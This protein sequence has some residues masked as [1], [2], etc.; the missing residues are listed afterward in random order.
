[1]LHARFGC[2]LLLTLFGSM[3]CSSRP[4]ESH[5][6]EQVQVAI[7]ASADAKGGSAY[8]WRSVAIGGGG[9][10]S[11]QSMDRSGTTHVV[12]ADVYGAYIWEDRRDRWEPLIT[13][14]S[15]PAD[16]LGQAPFKQGVYE[17]VVAPSNPHRIYLAVKDAVYRSDDRGQH[18]IRAWSRTQSLKFEPNGAYR[19][20]GPFMD[21]SPTDPDTVLLGTPADGLW[22][23]SDGG[24][25]WA[26]VDSVPL[27][28]D[29]DPKKKGI[30]TPGIGIIRDPVSGELIAS[31]A[32]NG[33]Y[34]STDGGQRFTPLGGPSSGPGPQQVQHGIFAADHAFIGT[35]P[36]A[37]TVWRFADGRW[38]DIGATVAA[39]PQRFSAIAMNPADG[40]IFVFDNG[41]TGY[42][43][44]DNGQSW[45][46]LTRGVSAG[47]KDP[48]WLGKIDHASYFGVSVALFDPKVPGRLWA[49][50][51]T[52]VYRA[53]LPPIEFWLSWV[54]QTRG[55]EELVANDVIAPP[56]GSPV[57]AAWDFGIH[58]KPD[59][60]QY[61][62]TW[63]PEPRS[64]ISAQQVDWSVANPRFIVT[65]ASD[66]RLGCCSDDGKSVLAGYSEDGGMTWTRFPTLPT[67]PGT[68]PG[69]PWA[70][71]FGTIAVS[72]GDTNNI[73]WE[74]SFNRS[75]YYTLD[76]G[77]TWSRVVLAGELLPFTGSHVA[78]HLARRTLVAD[79][80]VGGRFYL[81]HSGEW[82]N[83]ALKGVWRTDDGGRNWR[84]VFTGEV[85]PFS[86]F[87]AKLR[88]V[89]G[90]AG[91]LFFSSSVLGT[92]GDT[93]L[94]R[95]ENGG[96]TWTI[97][98][99]IN[100]VDDIAFGKAAPGADYPAI[101][102]SGQINGR[103]GLWRSLDNAA[104]WQMISVYPMGRVDQVN[105]VAADLERFGRVYVGFVGSGWVYGDIGNC[106]TVPFTMDLTSDCQLITAE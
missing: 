14:T 39:R 1:M 25:N 24:K 11:G 85:A 38:T 23:T 57:F 18:F 101:Y 104:H 42:R 66:I 102:L 105:V 73:V 8:L 97:L 48:P 103:Y 94:R 50:S 7:K 21:V 98:G 64:L 96:E 77:K 44:A 36:V 106:Q 61:S 43:S 45:R 22:R 89:P 74:P 79:R 4:A 27:P 65:N 37:R 68:K 41:G 62:V 75:P 70:M 63:G 72:S 10:L 78:P 93:R 46:R 29:I 54:S 31:S 58:T 3:A 60:D 32:G 34:K 16:E 82:G 84:H 9:Y 56:G 30:Q 17:V 15:M 49:T 20:F 95:S 12:R 13:S 40:T 59:L 55:I 83:N 19:F 69:D 91:H 86:T 87:A 5:S 26:R 81:L 100:E 35:D 80:A 47:D 51:G 99:N 2:V 76:R 92:G 67:P 33:L 88:A 53:D 52:G 90:K 28:R 71:S 6:G